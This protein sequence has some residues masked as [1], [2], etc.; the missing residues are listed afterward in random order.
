LV[1]KEIFY[2]IFKYFI[3]I[4]FYNKCGFPYIVQKI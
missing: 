2:Y 3:S 4:A 1:C